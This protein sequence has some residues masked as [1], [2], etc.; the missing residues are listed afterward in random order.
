MA[1]AQASQ[2]DEEGTH[3]LKPVPPGNP[4][5]LRSCGTG[6]SLWSFSTACGAQSCTRVAPLLGRQSQ[7]GADRVEFDIRFHFLE[8]VRTSNPVIEGFVLPEGLAGAVQDGV[9]LA[10]GLALD[11]CGDFG[12][13]DSR[14]DQNV[15]VVRH[16]HE[17]VQV[18]VCRLV[19]E[20]ADDAIGDFGAAQP[21]GADRG[22]VQEAVL[23]DEAAALRNHRLKPVPLGIRTVELLRLRAHRL[24]P[25]PLFRQES[26][27]FGKSTGQTPGDEEGSCCGMPVR[28]VATIHSTQEVGQSGGESQTR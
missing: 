23:F 17:G 28:K 6:F 21:G 1:V 2:T 15:D 18:E 10:G 14:R 3:G 16:D 4:K 27:V 19:A 7:S 5:M 26:V 25:V 20:S 13:F 11:P 12:K 9:G 8:L 22:A 24:K